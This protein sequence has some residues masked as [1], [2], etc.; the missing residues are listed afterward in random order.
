MSSLCDASLVEKRGEVGLYCSNLNCSKIVCAK[1]EYWASK[2]AM[3][4]DKVGTCYYSTA[5]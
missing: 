5:L 2:E 1:I 4:I 3:D